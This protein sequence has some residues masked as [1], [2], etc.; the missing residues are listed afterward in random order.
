MKQIRMR[1][2]FRKLQYARSALHRRVRE[3]QMLAR[4]FQA[5][6]RPILAQIVPIRR[7]NLS[8][9]YC[10]EYDAVSKPVPTAEM[11]RR[12][13]LLAALG[14]MVIEISGGEPLLHPELDEII[15]R[16][17]QCG[18]LAG[19]LT[20]GYPLTAERIRRLNRVG[21]DHLQISI[22]NVTP[23][24]VSKKSL[25][26]L[27]GKLQL[28]ARYADFAVNI[29]S[30]LG[31]TLRN[32]SDALRIAQR[33]LE[34]GFTATVG[35]IHN[36]SGQ[37][38]A[39]TSEQRQ[40]Y[41]QI[42]R[43]TNPFYSMAKHNPFQQKL[44]AGLPNDWHCR[45][46]SRYLYICEDGLVHWCSQQRGYPAVPLE[47][48]TREDLEREFHTMKSC[49]PYCTVSCVHRVALVD[50]LRERP[51]ETLMELTPGRERGIRAPWTVNLLR[52][53]FVTGRQRELFRKAAARLLGVN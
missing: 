10:N 39:L 7:C 51:F 41:E 33:A 17:R 15:R 14:T 3:A 13:D 26:V 27:D 35:L 32:P 47:M 48:Y 1:S 34:L 50:N 44:V 8:C 42:G 30:V 4:A 25:N 43:L 20:N 31:G 19:V 29:N 12:I 38:V 28:L 2:A 11:L 22:D 23:D 24:D 46:G 49:A 9:T 36:S 21:L 5:P 53:M 16:I 45:A 52:W 6:R 37:L 18:I 40:V